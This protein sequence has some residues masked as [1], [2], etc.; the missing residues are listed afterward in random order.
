MVLTISNCYTEK[1]LFF[2]LFTRPSRLNYYKSR[3]LIKEFCCFM[4]FDLII[5]DNFD[6]YQKEKNTI[7]AIFYNMIELFFIFKKYYLYLINNI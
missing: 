1:N 3:L 7:F 6:R 2:L 5:Y 4:N